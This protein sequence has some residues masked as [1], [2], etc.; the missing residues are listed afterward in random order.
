GES[1]LADEGTVA[2]H[3]EEALADQLR[4]VRSSAHRGRDPSGGEIGL[5]QGA[6]RRGRGEPRRSTGDDGRIDGQGD[7]LPGSVVREA[8]LG[9][10]EYGA[11]AHI[12][13]RAAG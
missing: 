11:V 12:A 3:A 9:G 7:L 2:A 5:R 8:Q 1:G 4:V 13:Q 10:L 6:R